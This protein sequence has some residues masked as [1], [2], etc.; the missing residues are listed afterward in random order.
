VTAPKRGP[1]R[2]PLPAEQRR[3]RRVSPAFTAKELELLEARAEFA[4]VPVAEFVRLSALG[5]LWD[6]VGEGT[7]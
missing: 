1:G 7:K 6:G 5:T 3:S 2:P 4:G